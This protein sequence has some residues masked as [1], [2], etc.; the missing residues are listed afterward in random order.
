MC[1]ANS[2]FVTE[3][4]DPVFDFTFEFDG[5]PEEVFALGVYGYLR[6]G[7]EM[8]PLALHLIQYIR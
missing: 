8:E 7:R 1:V 2:F 3:G 6:Y 4:R 5:Y